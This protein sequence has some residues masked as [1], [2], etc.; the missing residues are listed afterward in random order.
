MEIITISAAEMFYEELKDAPGLNPIMPSGAMY[1]M[2]SFGPFFAKN[3][4]NFRLESTWSA[5]LQSIAIWN[6][7]KN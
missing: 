1:M 6:S 3:Y 7:F 5:S 2:V 4:V